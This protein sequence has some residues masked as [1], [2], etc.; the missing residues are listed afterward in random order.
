MILD[1]YCHKP[2]RSKW[3]MKIESSVSN[4]EWK[5]SRSWVPNIRLLVAREEI[6]CSIAHS[7][8]SSYPNLSLKYAASLSWKKFTVIIYNFMWVKGKE[9]LRGPFLG[10]NLIPLVEISSSQFGELFGVPIT[11]KN[12]KSAIKIR[13]KMIHRSI[14]RIFQKWN[15]RSEPCIELCIEYFCHKAK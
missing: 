12:S 2:D 9:I 14:L 1:S 13:S 15:G 5:T 7:F 6:I 10:E 3:S 4:A 11:V 8:T